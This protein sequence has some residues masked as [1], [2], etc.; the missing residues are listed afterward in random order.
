MKS[1]AATA[2]TV[3]LILAGSCFGQDKPSVFLQS[4]SHG[5]T[6]NAKRD[7]S[8]EMAKDFERH[9]PDTKVTLFQDRA[10]Y[11]VILN[12][13]E[14]GLLYRDNQMEVAD[15]SGDLLMTREKGGIKGGV[16]GV[17]AAILSDW[18][19]A[20]RPVVGDMK[21]SSPE[22]GVKSSQPT[23]MQLVELAPP[24]YS[25]KVETPY[26]IAET[27]ADANWWV[28]TRDLEAAAKRSKQHADCLN[29]AASNPSITCK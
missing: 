16:K 2:A 22:V 10:N 4:L 19:G 15:K 27:S 3:A 12:H 28:N 24:A 14:V 7:Q 9:C 29:L 26:P 13:I 1:S 20:H 17:C 11:T 23:Q 5:N 8:I 25:A 6:W 18:S 21:G